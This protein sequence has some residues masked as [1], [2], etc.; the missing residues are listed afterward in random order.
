[1]KLRP[2]RAVVDL[3]ALAS[4]YRTLARAVPQGVDLMPVVKAD[5]YGH[6]AVPVARRL[7]EEGAP[8]LAIAVVEEGTELRRGGIEV[9]LLV[10]GWIGSDQLET[11]VAHRLTP[12]AHS[13]AQ[14]REL[15]E[16]AEAKRES[17]KLHVK[18]DTGM[19]RLGILPTEL[20]EVLGLLARAKE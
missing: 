19:T 8:L 12:N 16:F 15:V 4:N 20:S 6:G 11:L 18:L 2:T 17:L 13:P 7:V 5:A 1:V 3:D 10:M 14:L 9:P